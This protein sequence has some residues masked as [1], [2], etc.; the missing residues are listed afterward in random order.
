MKNQKHKSHLWRKAAVIAL[1]LSAVL[2]IGVERFTPVYINSWVIRF[3]LYLIA[4]TI[5]VAL[6]LMQVAKLNVLKSVVIAF[7]TVALAA[8]TK[9]FFTWEDDW[10]T[11]TVIYAN[12]DDLQKTI[13]LQ[14]RGAR[15]AFGYRERVVSRERLVPFV[16]YVTD[17]DTVKLDP[18]WKRVD[19]KVNNLHLKELNDQVVE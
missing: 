5:A 17:V 15:F 10:K 2:L 11:Q 1:F 8:G 12:T 4:G 6:F 9:A 3:V 19:K 7:V 14:M 13:E 18:S 16:D